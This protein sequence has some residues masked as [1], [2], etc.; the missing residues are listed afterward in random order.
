MSNIDLSKVDPGDILI[1]STG[2]LYECQR[3]VSTNNTDTVTFGNAGI[4]GVDGPLQ[5]EVLTAVDSNSNE[6]ARTYVPLR[7]KDADYIYIAPAYDAQLIAHYKA[8][9]VVAAQK[10]CNA[11]NQVRSIGERFTFTT[12]YRFEEYKHLVK[13]ARTRPYSL[14]EEERQQLLE[15]V[16]LSEAPLIEEIKQDAHDIE[17]VID[18]LVEQE[19]A[20]ESFLMEGSKPLG[21]YARLTSPKTGS[22]LSV[23]AFVGEGIF[24]TTNQHDNPETH[25][26]LVAD[27]IDNKMML[28]SPDGTQGSDDDG[29][30]LL[31][32]LIAFDG[33][34]AGFLKPRSFSYPCP[35]CNGDE[36]AG[37]LP[38]W[39][40]PEDC[41]GTINELRLEYHD[42][43][44]SHGDVCDIR[45]V[46]QNAVTNVA[47]FRDLERWRLQATRSL[48]EK[49]N[50]PDKKGLAYR[51]AM[52][53]L[54]ERS[55]GVLE[56]IFATLANHVKPALEECI[57]EESEN[58]KALSVTLA[59]NLA[60]IAAYNNSK[61]R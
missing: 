4:F 54:S 56:G 23:G 27:C 8:D 21:K 28:K 30:V 45:I 59:R 44:G 47:A 53:A 14:T 10:H 61:S 37:F 31:D 19:R 15:Y 6:Y 5:R 33:A 35:E 18:E 58:I 60:T 13:A 51:A 57:Y 42:S 52:G 38:S 3:V 48:L 22:P 46:P 40:D 9:Q 24:F 34:Y 25:A 41:S 49:V 26:F 17:T 50:A 11:L 7:T 29:Q 36:P 1:K 55:L 20:R 43:S 2:P 32:E 12:P 16:K 39:H